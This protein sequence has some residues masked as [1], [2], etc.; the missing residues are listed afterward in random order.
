MAKRYAESLSFPA[1]T[2]TA[3]TIAQQMIAW[4]QHQ[5]CDGFVI[6][7]TYIDENEDRFLEQVVPRLQDAGVFR[8]AYQPGTLRDR[9]GFAKPANRF[10]S[11][12]SD[13]IV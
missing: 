6:L 8:K 3:D 13:E 11:T 7:P 2:G 10:R 12:L 1:P 5:A 4:Y 9:L